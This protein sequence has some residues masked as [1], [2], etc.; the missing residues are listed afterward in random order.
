[1]MGLLIALNVKK[2]IAVPHLGL[3]GGTQWDRG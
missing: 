3:S 1:M 2:G